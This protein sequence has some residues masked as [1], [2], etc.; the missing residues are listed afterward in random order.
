MS[1]RKT[2]HLFFL[3]GFATAPR[4]LE[5]MEQ[6][7]RTRYNDLGSEVNSELLF[8]YGD[9]GRNRAIQSLEIVHDISLGLSR[10][11]RSI[12]GQ[13]VVE[14]VRSAYLRP[15][16]QLIFIGH[17]AGGVAALHAAQL[18]V[19]QFG[20]LA[21]FR[22]VKIGSPKSAIPAELK[23]HTAY[24]YSLNGSRKDPICQLGTWGGWEKGALSVP[25]WNPT[26]H[27]PRHNSAIPLLGG[28]PDYFRTGTPYMDTSGLSNMAKTSE[29]IWNWLFPDP[30]YRTGMHS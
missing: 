27:A 17:S 13:K 4:F 6:E 7:F 21:E 9:W 14:A 25:K 24:F 22:I 30:I 3:A 16:D 10:R 1:D 19:A 12:G 18:L 26:L 11:D 20:K 8:P 28:H 23:D 15:Q 2:V 5:G 29:M